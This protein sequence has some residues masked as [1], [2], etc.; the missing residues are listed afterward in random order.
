MQN[1]STGDVSS[2]EDVSSGEGSDAEV[3]RSEKKKGLI[4][5]KTENVITRMRDIIAQWDVFTSRSESP[6]FVACLKVSV[7]FIPVLI[8]MCL[9]DTMAIVFFEIPHHCWMD[10]P[11]FL[12]VSLTNKRLELNYD[13]CFFTFCENEMEYFF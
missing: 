8:T 3:H 13:D 1:I 11:G 7:W 9:W 10:H 6:P 5:Q 2:L 12:L 4:Y